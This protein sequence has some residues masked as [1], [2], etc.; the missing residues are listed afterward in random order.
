MGDILGYYTDAVA[1]ESFLGTA[2]TRR[3]VLQHLKLIGYELSTAV[4]AVAELTVTVPV[5]DPPATPN[6][7]SVPIKVLSGNTFVTASTPDAPSVRFEYTGADEFVLDP[8]KDNWVRVGGLFEAKKRLPVTEGRRIEE[9]IGTSDGSTHQ[10]HPLPHPKVILRPAGPDPDVTVVAGSDT[11]TRQE[12]LAFSGAGQPHFVVEVDEQDRA[13]VVFGEKV[14]VADTEIRAVYRVGGGAHGNVS[15]RTIGI[16]NAPQLSSAAAKVTNEERATGG[17]ERETIPHAVRQGPAVFRAGGRA[18]TAAD[19]ET[20]ALAFGGVGKVRARAGRGGVVQL[21]VAPAGGGSADTLRDGLTAYFADKRAI[22][23]RVEIADAE[24]AAIYVHAEVDV[25]LY[26]SDT[27]VEA[28]VRAAVREVLSLDRSDFGQ[29]VYL[30]KFVTAIEAV[31][32][33]AGV[34]IAEFA[35]VDQPAGTV[36]RSGKISLTETQVAR[37]PGPQDP[38]RTGWEPGDLINGVRLTVSGGFR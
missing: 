17:A 10:R 18:V 34:N 23:T 22:G 24:Y 3:A 31:D 30:S 12:T 20:L 15:A 14:P 36:E 8:G 4:P 11:W 28:Q 37:A 38:P 19:Y 6:P 2:Q 21:T 5:P 27:R 29:T 9:V 35:T 16:D 7:P 26:S 33:V 25:E 32:G 1:N 13:T